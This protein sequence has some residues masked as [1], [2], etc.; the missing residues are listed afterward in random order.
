MGTL[1]VTSSDEMEAALETFFEDH[2]Q[3]LDKSELARDTLR[4]LL[5]T[6]RLSPRTLNDDRVSREQIDTGDVVALD[7]G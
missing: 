3:Y 4:L 6:P 1:T 7:D 5:D 2:S